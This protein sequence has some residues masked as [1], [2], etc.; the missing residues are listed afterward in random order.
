MSNRSDWDVV[1]I[2]GGIAGLCS[3]YYL[4]L[5][6]K[7]VAVIEAGAV[8]AQ[9]SGV[10][11]GGLR[12][13]GRA[14]AELPLS[15]R[16]R[17]E[18]RK[19]EA[20]IGERC[21]VEFTGHVEIADRPDHMASLE[22]W[23]KMAEGYGVKPLL[24]SAA[25]TKRRFPWIGSEVLGGC[26]V[27]DD[28]AA[29]PRLVAPNFALAARTLGARIC[30]FNPVR[31]VSHD[32]EHFIVETENSGVLRGINLVNASGAWGGRLAAQLGETFPLDVM[33]PQMVVSEPFPLTVTSTVDYPVNG[34]FFYARQIDRG[35]LLFGRGPGRADLDSRRAQYVPQNAFDAAR[36]AM[37]VLPFLRGRSFIRTWSGVEGK[38]ADSLPFLGRSR[39]HPGLIHAFGFS[40]HGFQL[41]P[42]VGLVV[43]ELIV[44]GKTATQ[45]DACNP[46]RFEKGQ[47]SS[48]AA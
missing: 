1:V 17:S 20:L 27:A 23:A 48:D 12:T 7:R 34:R 14:E 5:R 30:E 10:N 6:G 45:I 42:G 4:A 38:T 2:G 28:G 35:N 41:G 39:S 3:A 18:W 33:A 25:A 22:T 11:F 46:Y 9:A 29:N 32:G 13:N 31:T 21:D 44:D 16:A 15:V 24:L 36:I 26:F 8:G 19:I 37:D 47:E 40:G 43:A